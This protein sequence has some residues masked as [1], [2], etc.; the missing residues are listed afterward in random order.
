MPTALPIHRCRRE[1]EA[2]L[3]AGVNCVIVAPTGTGK[4]TQVPQFLCDGAPGAGQVLV[5]EPRRLAARL[6]AQ[7]VAEERGTPLG[8]EVGFQTRFENAVSAATR[9]RFITEGILP[10]LLLADPGLAGIGTLVFDEFHERSLASDLSLALARALQRERR[11]DLRLVVM[12]ATLAP[13]PLLTCLAPARLVTAHAR[14]Y[15]VDIRYA[16]PPPRTPPWGTAAAAVAGLL[17][18]GLAGDVL[19]FQPGAYE[20]RRTLA[21]LAAAALPEAVLALP[22]YGDLPPER[23]RAVMAPAPRRKVIVAT[24]IAETSLTIPGVRHVVDCGL[25]RIS[26]HDPARGF[27]TLLTEGISR[28]EADQRAGRAGREGPGVC[29]RLWSPLE[30]NGRL[31]ARPPEVCRVDLSEAVLQ[32]RLLRFASPAA[33][34][35]FEPPEAGALAAADAFLAALGALDPAGTVTPLG[36]RLAELPLHPRLGRLLLE[37]DRLGCLDEAAL[38]AA[39][40][41]EGA[42]PARPG[43]AS[44]HPAPAPA[45]LESDFHQPL[46][47]LQAARHGR[48]PA[49]D[50]AAEALRPLLRTHAFYLQACR[51]R[52]LDV[53]RRSPHPDEAL[54][55]CLLLAYPD[56]L[57]R[58]R[59]RTRLCELRNGRRGELAAG[60]AVHDAAF[61]VATDIRETGG[62]GQTPRVLLSGCCAVREEWLREGLPATAWRREEE[63]AWNDDAQQVESCRRLYCLDVLVE[64]RRSVDARPPP[65]ADR[66]LAERILERNLPLDGWTAEAEAWVARV[67]WAAGQF[68][69]RGLI[70]Y[71]PADLAVLVHELC[72]GE[73]RYAR[74][75]AKPLLPGL[76]AMLSHA[77]AQF[78]ERMAPDAFRLPNGRR[79]RLEYRPG[80]PPHGRA[81]IQELYDL[82]ATPRVAD[83]R[84]PVLL[85]ILAP[86]QRPV[87]ITDDLAGFWERHYPAVRKT[88]ARRYPKHE[89]R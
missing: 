38:V 18:E 47:L 67:R 21:A 6:L 72:A 71:E 66:L 10:R 25:A 53:R 78:V 64:E 75:R 12:S 37:A 63:L 40:L 33:F 31:P 82:R 36:R 26:R 50:P 60:T 7:R 51:R 29:I 83:G 34:P 1:I 15:P 61:L 4:S 44:T 48:T 88:L 11:P 45:D 20:I 80:Q 9:I 62:R 32:I 59:G 84:V 42:A 5:L 22:L 24:N 52:G 73:N 85:E 70:R 79:V 57:A 16:A 41:S 14:Q 89:W 30:H 13:E 43:E 86:N 55:R 76:R 49:G 28:A 3:S 39:L 65:G 58:R 27:T 46:A 54:A 23:Q 35:W 19:V 56:R 68:P 81:R 2:A 8:A 74:V 69:E 87:Q 17:R 77:D